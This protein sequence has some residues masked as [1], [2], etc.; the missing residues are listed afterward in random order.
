MLEGSGAS[1]YAWSQGAVDGVYFSPTIDMTYFV[2][3]VDTNGCIN[4]DSICS[5]CT[6][7]GIDSV[8][9]VDVQYGN[10]AAIFTNTTG[11]TT[12]YVYDWDLDGFG[13]LD[14]GPNLFYQSGQYQ[15]NVH[16]S[17]GVWIVQW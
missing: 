16:D 9:I 3:G 15:L 2:Q 12:P 4:T 1:T 11:G 6:I 17:L 5:N 14:D 8:G 7:N 10:D 13:D